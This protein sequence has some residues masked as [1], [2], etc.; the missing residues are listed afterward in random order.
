MHANRSSTPA[1]P[2]QCLLAAVVGQNFGTRQATGQTPLPA[3][4]SVLTARAIVGSAEA[5]QAAARAQTAAA[6]A[7]LAAAE[8]GQHDAQRQLAYATVVAPVTGRIGNR[9][10]ET[11]DRVQAGQILVAVAEPETWIVANFK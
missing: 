1:D 6:H 2:R 3:P 8:A 5:A 4:T 10:R 7:G 11:G 9:H